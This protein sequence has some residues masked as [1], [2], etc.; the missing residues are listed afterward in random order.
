[1]H[2]KADLMDQLGKVKRVIEKVMPVTEVLLVVDATTGQNG[3]TQAKVFADAVELTGIILTK[4]DGSARGG[5]A[6]AIE[7]SLGVPVKWIGTGE[8]ATDFL[9]FDSKA[10]IEA[11]I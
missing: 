9:P 11:L 8:T 10:Y 7:A 1:M 6:L 2:T 5:I 3:L 4:T